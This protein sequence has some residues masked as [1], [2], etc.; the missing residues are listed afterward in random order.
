MTGEF[1]ALLR[2]HSILSRTLPAEDGPAGYRG[3]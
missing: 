3:V 1:Y 2:Q